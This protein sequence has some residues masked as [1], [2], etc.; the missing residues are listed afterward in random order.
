VSESQRV[1]KL[2]GAVRDEY[3]SV[4]TALRTVSD[5]LTWDSVAARLQDEYGF[6]VSSSPKNK[7]KALN[8][9]EVKQRKDRPKCYS[10]GKVGH[11]I[12]DCNNKDDCC[13]FPTVGTL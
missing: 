11:K 12:R 13:L 6:R 9:Q 7:K 2:L 4:V 1:A 10:C 8:A 3:E 5:K